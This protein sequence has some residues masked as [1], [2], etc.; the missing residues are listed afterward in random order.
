MKKVLQN[1]GCNQM[2][3]YLAASIVACFAFRQVI[4]S[5]ATYV[6]VMAAEG[7]IGV[8]GYYIYERYMIKKGRKTS[9]I[10]S[11]ILIGIFAMQCLYVIA[12]EMMYCHFT[13][14]AVQWIFTV[15][16]FGGIIGA[17][18]LVFRLKRK[19]E[20]TDEQMVSFMIFMTFLFHLL[21]AQFTAPTNPSRQNDTIQFTSGGGHLG[22]I[23]YVWANG[24]LPQADPRSLWEFSQPPLYYLL[25]GY[26]CKL[27]SL[28]GINVIKVAENIQFLSVFMVTLTTIYIDK[29]MVQ[30]KMKAE[31]RAWGILIMSCLPY[32]SYL[33]GAV[34]NDV[35]FVL[36]S[37]MSFYYALEWYENPKWILLISD[38]LLTGLL[39]MTKSSGA[40]V[41]PAIA[42]IF[43]LRFLKDKGKR[44]TRLV[45]YLVF[46]VI[47]LP[48]GLWWNVRNMVRF[49]MPFLY[50][51]EPSTSSVQY[52]PDYSIRERLF[53]FR[54]Q[55]N[56]PY[57]EIFNTSP[58]VDHNIIISTVKTLVFSHSTEVM[59]TNITKFW[60][61]IS[62]YMTVICVIM[63]VALGIVGLCK[64]NIAKYYKIAWIILCGSYFI[65]YLN[66]NLQYPFVHTMHARYLLPVIFMAVP[67][68]I[69]GMEWLGTCLEKRNSQWKEILRYGFICYGVCYFSV[70]QCYIMEI[71]VLAKEWL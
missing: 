18:F 10:V 27:S 47:S 69:K 45:Q 13:E 48:I 71:M 57:T 34:N 40:L 54:N 16:L 26:W 12:G 29:I 56:H 20:I 2:L 68:M 25:S 22:Y 7:C 66:F 17:F 67:W 14:D 37:V 1:L 31:S 63:L 52:I 35:L 39:V 32:T 4:S 23:W 58:E 59:A 53:D 5:Y 51:N 55:L 33:S 70:V 9:K 65:F 19:N 64:S 42:S 15:L 11:V 6:I 43:I 44:I 8:I 3:V 30:M 36:L 46:G 50:V 49:D 38:A 21:Y 60:G 61:M 62:L 24:T 41:A 28:F